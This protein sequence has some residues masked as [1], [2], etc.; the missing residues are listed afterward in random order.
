MRGLE[1]GKLRKTGTRETANRISYASSFRPTE[2]II[3]M[4]A[5]SVHWILL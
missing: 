4:T 3:M 2:V 1:L 5:Q